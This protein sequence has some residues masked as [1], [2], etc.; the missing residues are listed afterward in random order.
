ML[1]TFMQVSQEGIGA[2]DFSAET[3]NKLTAPLSADVGSPIAADLGVPLSTPSPSL[4]PAYTAPPPRNGVQVYAAVNKD[5]REPELRQMF[6]SVPGLDHCAMLPHQQT[7]IFE[8]G[9]EA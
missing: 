3:M 1:V 9:H 6:G 2:F 4:Q 5:V 8:V 7:G